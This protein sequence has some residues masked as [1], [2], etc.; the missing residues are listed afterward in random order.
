MSPIPAFAS[1]CFKAAGLEHIP[2]DSFQDTPRVLRAL[3]TSGYSAQ[4]PPDH[5]KGKLH[6]RLEKLNIA[7]INI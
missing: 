4:L 3:S 7:K 2:L 1:A 6:E 5:P